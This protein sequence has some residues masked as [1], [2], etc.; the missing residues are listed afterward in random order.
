MRQIQPKV[1]RKHLYSIVIDQ[2]VPSKSLVSWNAGYDRPT[3]GL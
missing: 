3:G 2:N 1:L